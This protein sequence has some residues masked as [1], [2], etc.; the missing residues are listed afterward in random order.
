MF[1]LL[2]EMFQILEIM[3]H[4]LEEMFQI[5][6]EMFQTRIL[7]NLNLKDL[8][9]FLVLLD[10]LPSLLNPPLL[11]HIQMFQIQPI[12]HIHIFRPQIQL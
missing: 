2:E 7:L 11:T 5:P 3:F 12:F 10:N 8:N 1:Q 4:I 6:Q 9:I